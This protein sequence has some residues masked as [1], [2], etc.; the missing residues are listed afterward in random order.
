VCLACLEQELTRYSD[1]Q[2]SA[3][4]RTPTFGRGSE[5]AL[6]SPSDRPRQADPGPGSV[7]AASSV[8][9]AAELN[10]KV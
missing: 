7:P 3:R 10:E 2:A 9:P 6:T 8:C 4:L 5:Q 1:V